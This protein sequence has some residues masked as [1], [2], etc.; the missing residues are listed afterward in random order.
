[1]ENIDEE[2]KEIWKSEYLKTIAAFHNTV[3]GRFIVGRRDNGTYIGVSNPHDVLKAISDSIRTSLGISVDIRIQSIE[4]KM[5]IVADVPRGRPVVDYNG[6]YYERIGNTTQQIL[7]ERLKDIILSERNIHWMDLTSGLTPSELSAEAVRDFIQMGKGIHRIPEDVDPDDVDSILHRYGLLLKDGTVSITG[8]IL[9]SEHPRSINRG[10]FLKIGEF[11][12]DGVLRREDII[13]TPVIELPNRTMDLLF[14]KYIPPRFTYDGAL[15]KLSY[16]YPVDGL[17]ELIVNAVVHM[18][19]KVNEP[20]TVSIHPDHVEV[21]CY[22][23]L[24]DGWTVGTL[25]GRHRSI[26]R[27][28]TMADVFHDAGYVENWAQGIRK[29][30]S[31]CEGNGNPP[32]EFVLENDGLSAT[33]RPSSDAGSDSTVGSVIGTLTNNQIGILKALIS[34]P[35]SSGASLADVLGMSSKTVNRNLKV[36]HGL[37]LVVRDGER[38]HVRWSATIGASDIEGSD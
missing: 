29:V 18:D 7:G 26:P 24:P 34:N 31:D 32:P 25:T 19:Y 22:G 28:K 14:D 37:G 4:G 12:S 2:W 16:A 33:I 8:S 1:M 9:F 3:G 27:N 6:K 17:R 23:G 5:C 35:G 36:L 21:F 30:I 11:D 38:S 20:V 15:R 10:A 13:D